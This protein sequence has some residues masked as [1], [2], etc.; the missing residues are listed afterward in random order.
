M[1]NGTGQATTTASGT[2]DPTLALPTLR[3]LA[4]LVTAGAGTALGWLAVVRVAGYGGDVAAAGAAGS[5][6]V[7]GVSAASLL[8]ILPWRVRPV[9]SWV[10]AWLAAIVLRLVL[11][12]AMAYLLYSAAPLSGTPL[13]LSVATA[14]VIVQICEAAVLALYVKRLT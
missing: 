11:T 9:S 13:L 6:L 12:P 3:L 2:E 4:A 7:V 14:Y 5:A 10:N 8:A 1:T